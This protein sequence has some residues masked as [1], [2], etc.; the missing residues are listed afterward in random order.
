MVVPARLMEEKKQ[1]EGAV[2][3]LGCLGRGQ[4]AISKT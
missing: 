3:F 4:T 1:G 2:S